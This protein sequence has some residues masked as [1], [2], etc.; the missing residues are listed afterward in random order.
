MV[1]N[2]NYLPL[3]DCIITS[4][5]VIV[6]SQVAFYD[7]RGV[8]ISNPKAVAKAYFYG[9]FG[10]DLIAAFPVQ[11]ILAAASSS[12]NAK[13]DAADDKDSRL[14]KVI[15][16]V[17]RPT[18]RSTANASSRR[19]PSCGVGRGIFGMIGQPLRAPWERIWEII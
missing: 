6:A 2:C 1:Y 3:H 19:R 5:A 9:W 17:R 4:A 14:L 12:G 18:R 13:E 10:L 15:R 8:R 16:L 11:H 7:S